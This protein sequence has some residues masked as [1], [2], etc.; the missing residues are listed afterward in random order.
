MHLTLSIVV[1]HNAYLY[2]SFMTILITEI[3]GSSH[4]QLKIPVLPSIKRARE[5]TVRP[6]HNLVTDAQNSG[7]RRERPR[8]NYSLENTFPTT[9]LNTI[10]SL[11]HQECIHP[12]ILSMS[13]SIEA[14]IQRG[15]LKT[16]TS[17]KTL[18][19]TSLINMII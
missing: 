8:I 17:F 19:C 6:F 10:L 5:L 14:T 16:Q 18:N 9:L 1:L 2:L 15:S 11:C 13:M 4:V 3:N 7:D 12:F